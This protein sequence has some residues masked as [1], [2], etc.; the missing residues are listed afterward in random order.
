MRRWPILL[1]I[2]LTSACS[3]FDGDE[4]TRPAELVDIDNPIRLKEVWSKDFGDGSGDIRLGLLP[5]V[6]KGKVAAADAKGTLA[7]GDAET[8]KVLW[9]KKTGHPFSAGPT[10][11]D[12]RILIGSR[13]GAIL[14]FSL[15]DGTEL[16]QSPVSSEV[17]AA[18]VA[19]DG[20]VVIRALD[21]R[22]F[23]LDES[24]GTRLWVYDRGVPILTLRGSGRPLVR[25]GIVFFG[26]DDGKVV[27]LRIADG[28]VLWEQTLAASAGRTELER[29]VDI[30]GAMAIV[31]SELYV[32]G[33]QGRVAALAVD[34]GRILW[35]Q[36]MSSHQ[37]LAVSR[38]QLFV[39]DADSSVWALDRRS[40]G[41][42]WKQDI[43]K[44][45][46]LTGPEI[47]GDYVVVGDTEGY[48]HWL[49]L[50][51]GIQ[52]GRVKLDS[53]PI[54]LPAVVK[55][56]ILYAMSSDGHVGAYRIESD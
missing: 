46:H 6:G 48:L 11:I 19:Q 20:V 56:D 9:K 51:E 45:R 55:G 7:V 42:M 28:T 23:G 17:L 38:T 47:H 22:I 16:W 1:L 10:I 25:A 37:G 52:K 5:T 2:S 15:E 44:N 34:S 36:D 27:A 39:T 33:Y 50:D 30:D 40:G 24:D 18:P 31:A 32:T 29:L 4:E 53:S 35:V 3:W 12:D 14:A 21:G 41:T 43:F 54:H 13:E 26:T 8:G 49:S